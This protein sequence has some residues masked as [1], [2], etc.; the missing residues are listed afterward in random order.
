VALIEDQDIVYREA[1]VPGS[2]PPSP[3][4]APTDEGFRRR[5]ETD[6]TLLFRY[7]ALTFNGHRIHYDRDYALGVEGY[8]GL[9]VHGPLIATLLADLAQ[10]Q[11]DGAQLKRFAF[12]AISPLFDI[13][14]FGVCGRE[15]TRDR[16][17]LWARNH[18]GGLAMQATAEFA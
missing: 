5:V 17:A 9:V 14:P 3:P 13:H 16:L 1:A 2:M 8:P 7:S 18:E 12:K 6:A 15:E 11:R 4:A 10:R